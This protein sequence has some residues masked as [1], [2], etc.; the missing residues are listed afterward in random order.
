[1]STR[2]MPEGAGHRGTRPLLLLLTL[3]VGLALLACAGGTA[4]RQPSPATP[5]APLSA[6]LRQP[7]SELK[8]VPASVENPPEPA[9]VA[10]N[11]PSIA[12]VELTAPPGN[13][14]HDRA[15]SF[16]LPSATGGPESL[17]S[18]LGNEN[19]VLIFYRAFW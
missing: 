11:E 15:H 18:Y 16:V 17:E 14:V 12:P 1:M 9:A 6:S 4:L 5:T 13:E 7:I 10:N 2:K 8:S 19:V 3:A